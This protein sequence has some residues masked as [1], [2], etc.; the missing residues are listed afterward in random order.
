MFSRCYLASVCLDVAEMGG[1]KETVAASKCRRHSSRLMQML[2]VVRLSVPAAAAARRQRGRCCT[3]PS[4]GPPEA[5]SHAA[6]VLVLREGPVPAEHTEHLVF[7][8]CGHITA[9]LHGRKAKALS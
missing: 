1:V 6:A 3:A 2:V 9:C 5:P 8:A 4:L 7:N